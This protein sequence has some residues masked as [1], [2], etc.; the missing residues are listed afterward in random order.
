MLGVDHHG[1]G[2]PAAVSDRDWLTP[3][4][5]AEV[6]HDLVRALARGPIEIDEAS[7]APEHSLE[8]QVPFLQYVL[9]KPRFAALMVRFGP[10]DFLREVA[11]VVRTAV[12]E[13]DVLLL[14]STDFS[15]Y[16]TPEESDRLDHLAL[17][18]ILAR[19]GEELYRTVTEQDISMCG[20]APTTVLLLALARETLSARLL[21]WGH[22]GEAE[23]MRRVVGYASVLL[24]SR[25]P[26]GPSR[27]AA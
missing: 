15:H 26:L 4:G 21:R 12:A 7:H 14:A 11:D 9:P 20:I 17:E 16:V 13:R 2:V 3:L 18:A 22:S 6:D 23:P 24:E 5:P 19:D 27:P 25:H 10:L 8:V 1:A